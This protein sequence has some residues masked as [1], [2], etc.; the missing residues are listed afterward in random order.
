MIVAMIKLHPRPFVIA[1]FGAALFAIF[2]VASSWVVRRVVDRV[3]IPRFDAGQVATATALGGLGLIIGVGLVRATAVVVRRV[4]ATKAMWLVAETLTDDV[5][6]RLVRQPVPWHAR[7]ADGD[8][9]ARAGVDVDAA[10]GV[11]APIPFGTGTVVMI[12][13]AA[14]WMLITDLVL[15]AVAVVV[16]PVLMIV[17]L[18]YEKRV[19]RHYDEA[20]DHLG[21]FSAGVHESFEGVQL[22]KAYGAE[23]RETDRLATVA[24]C[25]L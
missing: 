9:V 17:N 16:F 10:V 3:I 11:L 21:V 20:Q 12:F 13:V 23:R 18:V 1:M 14:V 8:L 25:L 7:R 6:E 2:T 4:W 15:G 24:G 5:V 19:A 22:V